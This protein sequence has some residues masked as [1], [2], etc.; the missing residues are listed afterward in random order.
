MWDKAF[1]R[2]CMYLILFGLILVSA[3]KPAHVPLCRHNAVYQAVT[4]G[5]QSG[6]PVRIAVGRST[7]SQSKRHAQAQAYISGKWEYL[8]IYN[9]SVGVGSKDF[10]KPVAYYNIDDFSRLHLKIKN[11]N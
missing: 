9:S 2:K 3:C 11:A 1:T 7:L 5:D 10:F 8:K 6:Y 4:F